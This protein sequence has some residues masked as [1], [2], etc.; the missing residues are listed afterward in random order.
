MLLALL[1]AA[2]CT[3]AVPPGDDVAPPG[4]AGT[5]TV[6]ITV[7]GRPESFVRT[8]GTA[9]RI[10]GSDFRFVGVNIYDAA[11]TDRYSCNAGARM[12]DDELR[13]TLTFLRD[14]AGVSV[15]RFWAYQTYTQAGTDWTGVDRVIRIAR[16]LDIRVLPVLEDGPGNCTTSSDRV[17]KAKYR[18]DTWF[19]TGY[20]EPYGN[21]SMPYRDYVRVIT[22]HY[23]ADPTIMG[24]SMM[25][26]AD[27]SARDDRGR[28]VLVS[29]AQDIA[30]VIR[31]V[32]SNHLITLGTQSNGAPGASGPDFR[33]VYSLPDLDFSEVHDWG[34]W[35]AD[36]EPMPGADSGR[37]PDPASA[38]CAV[39]NAPIACS[40]AV[41]PQ[42]GK[43]LL[44]GEAGIDGRDA[45]ERATR[46]RQLGAK[47][48]AAFAAGAGGYLVWH[49]N[50][51]MTDGYDVL[52]DRP[53]PLFGVLHRTA[54]SIAG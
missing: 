25:N 35:G 30:G 38:A 53:D 4:N 43:P 18:G 32:D 37:P 54:A 20:R 5:S 41:A 23:A 42:L 3:A 47:M 45:T 39:S 14:T 52:V 27:T 7:P 48:N 15:V 12:S 9:F 11:A 26:E 34:Y 19:S 17:P 28:S 51:T 49:V 50:T 22:A 10:D 46:A 33:A 13:S 29:F 1:T 31:Q 40:F 6:A 36:D 8:A 21:A 44:V 16:D 2:G 24:W